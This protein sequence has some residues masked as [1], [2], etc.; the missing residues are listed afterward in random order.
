MT[1]LNSH[2]REA[3]AGLA[4]QP[5]E[6]GVRGLQQAV[7][8]RVERRRRT[9]WAVAA[10]VPALAVCLG[11]G[12]KFLAP[13]L[14]N[15][16]APSTHVAAFRSLGFQLQDGSRVEREAASTELRVVSDEPR[17]V[18]LEL[19]AGAAR[20]RVT[21]NTE[22]RFVVK[23]AGLNVE[24]VGTVFEVRR[25]SA[26]VEVKVQGGRV[27]VH[28][29]TVSALLSAGEAQSFPL[30]APATA[31]K[32]S[33]NAPASPE[34]KATDAA[35]AAAVDW[36]K[37]AREGKFAQAYPGMTA[38]PAPSASSGVDEL[39]LRADVA[40]L[41]GH[42]SEAVEPLRTLV[43]RFP[44]DSRAPSAS[45][46]LGRVHEQLGRPVEAAR[47]FAQTRAMQPAGPLAEDA[48]AREA[49]A[50]LASGARKQAE[51]R[52]RE[53]LERFPAGVRAQELRT[54]TGLR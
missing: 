23:V 4:F 1:D 33:S 34:V 54:R 47:A 17:L 5:G 20:F 48:L 28:G 40:R 41:S 49:L 9:R 46:T 50:L 45:F 18:E 43:A 53:Y 32:P 11:L 26:S 10:I 24:V 8:S 30:D 19:L 6:G 39:L 25:S 22:R 2:I 36:Q 52:A 13:S 12:V 7:L 51:A 15:S 29:A 31:E 21:S 16:E 44:R 42:P 38:A 37:L 14:P 27:R 35:R 3:S